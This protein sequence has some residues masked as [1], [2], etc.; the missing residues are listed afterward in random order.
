VVR[1]RRGNVSY[2]RIPGGEL[3]YGHFS[4][5]IHLW[6]RGRGYRIRKADYARFERKLKEAECK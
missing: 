5:K 4:G 6:F 1:V 2:W 3:Q